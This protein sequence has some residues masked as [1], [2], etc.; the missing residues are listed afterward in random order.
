MP[1]EV[2]QLSEDGAPL[3]DQVV[4]WLLLLRSG[5]ATEAEQ[6]AFQTWRAANPLHERAWQELVRAL[7]QT[8]GRLDESLPREG[9]PSP[10]RPARPTRNPATKR[11]DRRRFLGQ[12]FGLA[13]VAGL[14]LVATDL[15]YPLQNMWSDAASKTGERRH[16]SL[17]D[18]TELMLDARSR[19]NI[20][21]SDVQRSIQLLAGA[22]SLNIAPDHQRPLRVVTQQGSIEALGMG[23]SGPPAPDAHRPG[24]PP[25][26]TQFMV[27]QEAGRTLVVVQRQE[28]D[29][30]TQQGMRRQL[31][32]GSGARFD[33]SRVDMPRADLINEAAWQT[34]LI[35]VTARPL[36]QVIAAL[37]PYYNGVLRVST[38]AG[39]LM[40]TGRYTLDYVDGV[41]ATL[42]QQLPIVVRKVTPWITLVDVAHA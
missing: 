20:D 41:L 17:A 37:R 12:T 6:L 2:P 19:I 9:I 40:V 4:N 35:Q 11:I 13:S 22:I 27:R 25:Q 7:G 33:D 24:S 28:I 29:I 38:P 5:R 34:G 1:G 23:T 10:E 16:L 32:A 39:G 42:A 3:A 30:T 36:A 21:F 26:G 18:G 8:F 15:H 31:G 14:S